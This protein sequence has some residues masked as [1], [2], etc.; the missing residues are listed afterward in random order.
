[1]RCV[2]I[3]Y[4]E[5]VAW[6]W[7]NLRLFKVIMAIVEYEQALCTDEFC[8]C[9]LLDHLAHKVLKSTFVQYRYR[10]ICSIEF[11]LPCFFSFVFILLVVFTT[12]SCLFSIYHFLSYILVEL[13]KSLFIAL[14]ILEVVIIVVWS[15]ID[16]KVIHL[17]IPELRDLSKWII[18]RYYVISYIILPF[19]TEMLIQIQKF[20]HCGEF[21]A[22]IYYFWWKINWRK[23]SYKSFICNCSENIVAPWGGSAIHGLT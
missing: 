5:I 14:P 21:R 7:S 10:E 22:D 19:C 12:D 8:H 23:S 1:M 18:S 3:P 2:F 11:F 4:N 9:L 17:Q 20:I 16:S 13:N 6:E 15:N